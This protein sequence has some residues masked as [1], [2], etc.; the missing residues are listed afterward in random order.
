MLLEYQIFSV[1]FSSVPR[2]VSKWCVDKI[3]EVFFF[4]NLLKNKNDKK[5]VEFSDVLFNNVL[6]SI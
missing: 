5:P 3:Y 2:F 1:F 4:R 6:L